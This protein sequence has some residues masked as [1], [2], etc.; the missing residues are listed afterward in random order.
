LIVGGFNIN[1]Q[2]HSD[3]WVSNDGCN[4][5]LMTDSAPFGNRQSHGLVNHSEKLY[6]LGGH[7]GN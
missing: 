1:Y 3:I 4:W 7:N 2:A 5:I 6:L